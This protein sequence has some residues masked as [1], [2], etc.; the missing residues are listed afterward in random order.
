MKKIFQLIFVTK[1]I[2]YGILV[3]FVYSLN[4]IITDIWNL[5]EIKIMKYIFP[6]INLSFYSLMTNGDD[7]MNGMIELLN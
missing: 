4:I 2:I 1:E 3:E 6:E 5:P 7:R